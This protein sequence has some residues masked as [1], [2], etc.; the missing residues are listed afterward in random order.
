MNINNVG[1]KKVW[2]DEISLWRYLLCGCHHNSEI[3]SVKVVTKSL[4]NSNF[5]KNKVKYGV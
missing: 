1:R 3:S 5:T 2:T 4:T